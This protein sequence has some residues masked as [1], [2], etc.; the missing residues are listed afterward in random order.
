[1]KQTLV[2]W[3]SEPSRG[4]SARR[5]P[6]RF[7]RPH[8]E[9]LEDRRLLSG[10]QLDPAFGSGGTVLSFGNPS[11]QQVG[12][13]AALQ[14]D[15]KIVVAIDDQVPS[16]G[17]WSN[18]TVVVER[19][20][21]DG[22]L[23][24]TFGQGGMVSLNVPGFQSFAGDAIAIRPDGKIF[25]F[26]DAQSHY[27]GDL[28]LSESV[29]V[30]LNSDGSLDSSFGGTGFVVSPIYLN[31][32][33][34]T[35]FFLQPDGGFL[36]AGSS[37]LA[38]F[39]YDGSLDKTFG[40]GGVG[41]VYDGFSELSG[42]SEQTNGTIIVAGDT[43]TPVAGQPPSNPLRSAEVSIFD[44]NGILQTSFV[45]FGP[46]NGPI[47]TSNLSRGLVVQRDGGIVVAGD[48]GT[49][50]V[51][52]HFLPDGTPDT[53]F[54]NNGIVDTGISSSSTVAL[55]QAA[56]GDLLI[57]TSDASTKQ[58][59][60][61][62]FHPDGTA[63]LAF[64]SN[65]QTETNFGSGE[66]FSLVQNVLIQPDGNIVIDA[67]ES[68]PGSQ[69][70]VGLARFLGNWVPANTLPSRQSGHPPATVPNAEAGTAPVPAFTARGANTDAHTDMVTTSALALALGGPTPNPIAGPAVSLF[71]NFQGGSQALF[72]GTVTPGA[73]TGLH[74]L[75]LTY[76]GSGG[77]DAKTQ[78][79]AAGLAV[80]D[81]AFI[82][83]TDDV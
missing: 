29:F 17:P 73:T 7:F 64:G 68:V 41:F 44:S 9:S 3:L 51:L 45:A 27:D 35:Q 75:D 12:S 10:G 4:A 83:L 21:T 81:Q 49:H 15:G 82:N 16:T 50:V 62:A 34:Q 80:Q 31:E 53:S 25:L 6:K 42:I 1:M 28:T 66:N 36:V 39:K 30:R 24:G 13:Q 59:M 43:S 38:R 74:P 19:F 72:G 65:G 63:D 78:S 14:P 60:L 47:V 77:G 70:V 61:A 67:M 32:T 20:N 76:F 54:G 71:A 23:D 52:A 8:L 69:S 40:P 37:G 5:H 55:T 18:Y 2:R 33:V 48:D 58:I 56:N 11:F 57:A 22:S 46:T 26:G 79:D